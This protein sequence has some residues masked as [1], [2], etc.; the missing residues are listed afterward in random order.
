LQ[1]FLHKSDKAESTEV[2]TETS[3][4]VTQETVVGHEHTE[5]AEAIDRERHIVRL[6]PAMDQTPG[7]PY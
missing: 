4:P 1:N 6:P 5:T 3:A 2:C 7:W